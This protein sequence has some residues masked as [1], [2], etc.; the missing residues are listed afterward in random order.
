MATIV[1][2][3]GTESAGGW[4]GPWTV[5]FLL[6]LISSPE[7]TASGNATQVT[8]TNTQTF[9]GTTTLVANG[10]FSNYN[11]NGHPQSGTVNSFTYTTYFSA[12]VPV[13]MTV[14]GIS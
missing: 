4:K 2:S 3:G 13:T 9:G 11:A 5:G 1:F 8:F 10:S 14:T 7:T 12:G 6:S